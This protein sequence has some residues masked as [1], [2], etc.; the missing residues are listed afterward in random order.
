MLQFGIFKSE[1]YLR[2]RDRRHV[3]GSRASY[4][5]LN[6]GD[7]PTEEQ[8]RVFEDISRTL[9]TSNGTYRTTF[10]NRF[11]DLDDLAMRWMKKLYGTDTEVRVQDRAVSHALTSLE[12]AERLFQAFPLTLFEASDALFSL[13]KLS[14]PGRKTY[15]FEPNGQPLQY[16]NWPFVVS[17]QRPGSWRYPI[18]RLIAARAKRRFDQLLLPDGWMESK[19]EAAYQVAK[20]SCVH[21]RALQFSKR[22]PRFQLEAR[23]VFECLPDSCDV[24]RTMNILNM[25]YFSTD[26]LIEGIN[27]AFHSLKPGGIW[28]VGRTLEKDFSNQVTLLRKEHGGWKVLDRLGGGSEIEELALRASPV[29]APQ[30]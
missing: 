19:G 24:L 30:A 23:S 3:L 16:I 29:E 27:A 12:W 18:N 28:I 13:I 25:S 11:H 8:I 7:D 21:P 20:I 5:L 26:R 4:E 17:L 10:A 9:Q 1:E 15:V 14:L 2:A 6:V 22:N